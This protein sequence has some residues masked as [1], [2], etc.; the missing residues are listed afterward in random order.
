M[1]SIAITAWFLNRSLSTEEGSE[2]GGGKHLD[3]MA[4]KEMSGAARQSTTSLSP[5]LPPISQWKAKT[6]MTSPDRGGPA[7]PNAQGAETETPYQRLRAKISERQRAQAST[8]TA[9]M[10]A[11]FHEITP[12]ME[13]SAEDVKAWEELAEQFTEA[14]EGGEGDPSTPEYRKRWEEALSESDRLF[15]LY[16]G[17]RAF[18]LQGMQAQV[19]GAPGE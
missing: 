12:E 15:K 2:A 10:P 14:L 7:H 11:V 16:F 4:G 13:L 17:E 19:S 5:E 9:E 18:V 6:R 8:S 1:V 3:R